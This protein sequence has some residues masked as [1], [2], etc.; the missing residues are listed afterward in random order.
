MGQLRLSVLDQ[1]P[2]PA[3][4]TPADALNNS[5]SLA[6]H[7][8]ALG[9]TRLWYSEH[10]AMDLLAC[11][12]P[13]ILITRAAAETS[14]IR[15]G[16]GGIMLPHYSALKVAEVFSTLNAMF[17][18]RIDLGIGRAPGGGQLEA[19]ALRRNRKAPPADDFP[20]QLAELRAFLHPERWGS[21]P[22]AGVHPFAKIRVSPVAEG[23]PDVWLLGSSMWSAVTAAQQGLPYAFAHFFSP[24]QTRQAIEYYQRNFVPSPDRAKPEATLA[25]GVI[26]AETD[27]EA[28]RLH[29]SVRLLQ[30]RIRMDDR[31][32]VAEPNDALRELNE[33]LQPPSSNFPF[34]IGSADAPEDGEFPRY[35]VGT[36]DKVAAELRIVAGEL[37]LGEVIVNTITH[38]HAARLRSYTLLAGEMAL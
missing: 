3:G 8:D 6:R 15:V 10:H 28:R 26:C 38:D 14:R 7:V 24:V 32:P 34:T 4:F 12:A 35:L 1:S 9:Y 20:E 25:I 29:A 27:A 18:N 36:P 30:R 37:G 31:R 11:T 23:A 2:V 33:T 5:L 19:Y 17:P 16:S 21:I 22:D 13:E